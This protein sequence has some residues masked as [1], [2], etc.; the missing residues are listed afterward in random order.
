MTCANSS[1]GRTL[2]G[3]ARRSG[4]PRRWCHKGVPDTETS[5]E[6]VGRSRG[7][8]SATIHL[9]AEGRGKTITFL[10]TAERR[11]VAMF[12]PLMEQGAVKRA[13][14]GRP[15]RRPRRIVGGTGSSIG[16]IRTYCHRYRIRVTIPRKRNERRRG[17]FDRTI[18]RQRNRGTAHQ[19]LETVPPHCDPPG[20]ARRQ[21]RRQAHHRPPFAL[22]MTWQTGPGWP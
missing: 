13:G 14:P 16:T 4:A 1:A 6:A 10:V 17:P 11:E 20:K 18:Y 12:E 19:P 21:L 9:R 3:W 5:D 7:G 8:F 22:V 15:R 2:C